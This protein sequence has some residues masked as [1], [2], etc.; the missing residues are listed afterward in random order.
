MTMFT[1]RLQHTLL[2]TATLALPLSATLPIVFGPAA[3][4]AGSG[5]G[6]DHGGGNGGDHGGGNAGGNSGG[7]GSGGGAQANA[8]GHG[9]AALDRSGQA[10]GRGHGGSANGNLASAAGNL[11]AAH[12]SPNALAHAAPNSTV[13]RIAT[14]NRAMVSALAMPTGTRAQRAAR[15]DAIATARMGLAGAANKPLSGAVVARVDQQ[16]G[17]PRSNPNIGL[18]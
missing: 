9:G 11:N 18:R 7:N 10:A 3:A 6:G 5:N 14:Y 4:L 1:R 8:G 13:G 12:A 17:L 2:A 15:R 16:L